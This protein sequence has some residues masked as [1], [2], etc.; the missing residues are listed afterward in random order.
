MALQAHKRILRHINEAIRAETRE[1]ISKW[2]K[3]KPISHVYV[4]LLAWFF[5]EACEAF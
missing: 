3:N 1:N 5:C 2:P 4:I